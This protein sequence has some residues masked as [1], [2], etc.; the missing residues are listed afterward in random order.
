MKPYLSLPFTEPFKLA[1]TTGSLL[2]A[3]GSTARAGTIISYTGS[4]LTITGTSNKITFSLISG[5]T[6]IEP[7]ATTP[8]SIDT[9]QFSL[10]YLPPPANDPTK[11]IL[12]GTAVQ[13]DASVLHSDDFLVLLN[14]GDSVGSTSGNYKGNANSA[15]LWK[16]VGSGSEGPWVPGTTGYAGLQ[17]TNSV[18]SEINY[19][20][21]LITHGVDDSLTLVSFAY[22]S[23]G[24]SIVAG[25]IPEPSAWALILGGGT[26]AAAACRKRRRTKALAPASR[27]DGADD[28]PRGLFPQE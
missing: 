13:P 24:A 8:S 9:P 16:P 2:V 25:A 12:T 15:Y 22:D 1:L 21:A 19:G 28:S 20:W 14:A 23:S 27:A 5:Q 18:T 10:G 3:I 6:V 4:P 11:P 7:V 26:L 17:F